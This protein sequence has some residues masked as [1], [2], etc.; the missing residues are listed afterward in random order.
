MLPNIQGEPF[1][2]YAVGSPERQAL[3]EV[4]SPQ[5]N[6][7]NTRL[8]SHCHPDSSLRLL[9]SQAL[10]VA[11]NEVVDIPCVIGGK[12]VFT[13]DVMEHRMPSDHKHVLARYVAFVLRVCSRFYSR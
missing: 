11:K 13:G 5:N 7:F 10:V 6:S 2:H 1:K 9:L 12:K 8:I 3:K 4:H